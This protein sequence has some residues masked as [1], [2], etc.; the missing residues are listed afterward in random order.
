VA[1]TSGLLS[2]SRLCLTIDLWQISAIFAT[3][4]VGKPLVLCRFLCH[5][6]FRSR[7]S[8]RQVVQVAFGR[9]DDS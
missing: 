9:F 8:G 5:P 3:F 2:L 6:V 7:S 1:E 4:F